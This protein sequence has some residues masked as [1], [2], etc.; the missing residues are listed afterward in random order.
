MFSGGG[1]RKHADI[2]VIEIAQRWCYG[3]FVA[4]G[5]S[6]TT[7]TLCAEILLTRIT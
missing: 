7:A 2:Q 6:D 4:L 1:L 3:L 5:R